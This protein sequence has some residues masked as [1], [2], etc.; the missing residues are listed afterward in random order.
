MKIALL[1]DFL[2]ST[3]I[4]NY[5]FSLFEEMKKKAD[6]EMIFLDSEKTA[7]GKIGRVKNIRGVNFP[8]LKHLLNNAFV[9]PGRIPNGFDVYHASNQY[10]SHIVAGK[11]AS[12]VSCMD[13]I[14]SR[15]SAD[16]NPVVNFFWNSSLKQ[17]GC[18]K[19]IIAI[20][21]FTRHEIQ[22]QL[23]IPKE[24]IEVIPLAF[25]SKAFRPLNKKSARKEL[26]IAE[27]ANVVLNVG[28]EEKRKNI[29]TLLKAFALLAKKNNDALLLRVGEQRQETKKLIEQLGIGEK[30]RYLNNLSLERL[31][32]AYNA[33]DALAFCSY[34]E[35]FGLPVLEA[36]ACGCPVVAARA[37]SVPEITGEAAILIDN[38]LDE[39][40]FEKAILGI[41]DDFGLKKELERKGFV[42]A[43]KFSWKKNAEAT[44]RVY[45]EV[46]Q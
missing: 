41:F 20:S 35:G 31:A 8:A 1:N 16:Y 46:L 12:V 4:G 39:K 44:L 40:E 2:P 26:S 9:F 24:K 36:M 17:M 37:A 3:G 38:P 23:G 34:Y 29:P 14:S 22:R 32:L 18:A 28:S 45:G 10:I 13:I 11:N 7:P 5:A 21:N 42:Q 30:I 27:N 19:K 43:R 6:V 25:D 15:L 33:A